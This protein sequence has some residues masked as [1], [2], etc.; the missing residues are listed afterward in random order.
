M[1]APRVTPSK[2]ALAGGIPIITGP[3]ARRRFMVSLPVD[4]PY[5]VLVRLGAVLEPGHLPVVEVEA[6]SRSEAREIAAEM[7]AEQETTS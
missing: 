1:T 2:S 5:R 7:V 6:E 3:A 4:V